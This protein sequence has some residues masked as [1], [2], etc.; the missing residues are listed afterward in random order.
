MI[1]VYADG[2]ST[3]RSNKPG[4]WSYIIVKDGLVLTE[5]HGGD[6]KTTNNRMELLGAIEGLRALIQHQTIPPEAVELVSDSQYTLGMASGEYHPK[7][8]IDLATE[9]RR[10]AIKTDAKTRWVRGHSKDAYN[11]Q[12][13]TLAKQGKEEN[14]L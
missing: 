13:D 14:T 9:L 11:E 8:N 3:G 5:D 6:A 2:S 4:G 10:L 12:C 1:S 7:K